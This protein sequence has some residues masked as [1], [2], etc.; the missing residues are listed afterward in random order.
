MEVRVGRDGDVEEWLASDTALDRPVLVRFLGAEATPERRAGFIEAVR[1]ASAATHVHVAS[2]YAAADTEGGSYAVLEWTGGISVA[3]RIDA[4][5]PIEV[6]DFLPNA[7]G[8]AAG[9]ASLHAAGCVHGAID[10]SAVSFSTAHPAK[11]GAFGRS[12]G[13]GG[14]SA[15]TRA[16]AGVLRAGITGSTDSGL[17]PSDASPGLPVEVDQALDRAESGGI[18]ASG[19]AAALRAIPVAHSRQASGPWSWRWLVAMGAL[20]AAAL[21]VSILG[22]GIAADPG[23]PLLFPVTPPATTV[24]PPSTSTTPTTAA[25]GEAIELAFTAAV[26]DPFGDGVERDDDL[27]L[28]ADADPATAW[29]TERYYDPLR[30][31]KSGVGLIFNVQGTPTSIEFQAS[32]DTRFSIAWAPAVPDDFSLWDITGSGVVIGVPARLQVPERSGGVWLLWLTDLPAQGDDFY[33]EIWEVR[34]LR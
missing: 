13:T 15:D 30:L 34:F 20:L 2:V 14:A 29:R 6:A 16:L 1:A 18:D 31:L 22:L 7:A 21:L 24:P 8:L 33:A 5:E 9:L 19:L 27:P 23:S 10:S 25:A 28:I 11:L 12:P 26:H 32:H 17:T 3:H 4:G